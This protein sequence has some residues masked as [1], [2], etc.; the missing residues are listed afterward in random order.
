VGTSG[1][2]FYVGI[3]YPDADWT[4]TPDRRGQYV[5][6]CVLPTGQQANTTVFL[7]DRNQTRGH[8]L[9]ILVQFGCDNGDGPETGHLALFP[10]HLS[11]VSPQWS[12]D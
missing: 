7:V 12:T 3:R 9:T 4:N 10:I 5:V 1:P 2:I 11:T 8:P 6:S